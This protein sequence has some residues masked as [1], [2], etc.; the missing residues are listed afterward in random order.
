MGT[1]GPALNPQDLTLF[2]VSRASV[3]PLHKAEQSKCVSSP[4]RR[5]IWKLA[6]GRWLTLAVSCLVKEGSGPM[7]PEPLA[8]CPALDFM[9]SPWG[10][11]VAPSLSGIPHSFWGAQAGWGEDKG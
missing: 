6:P 4:S 7:E 1:V 2:G 5:G 10:C 9:T 3:S 11:P 8:V